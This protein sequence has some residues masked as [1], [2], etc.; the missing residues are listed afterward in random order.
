MSISALLHMCI[1]APLAAGVVALLVPKRLALLTKVLGVAVSAVMCIGAAGLFVA[2]RRAGG[3][4]LAAWPEWAGAWAGRPLL[5]LDGLSAL[6]LGASGVFVL[7]ISL[8]SAGFLSDEKVSPRSYWANFLWVAGAAAATLVSRDLLALTF[9]WAFMGIP[10]FLL[11]NL[12]SGEADAAAKKMLIVQG[13]TDGLLIL[14][15][16][17]IY[18]LT[19]S[20]DILQGSIPTSAAATAACLCVA[21]AALSKAGA[22]PLHSWVPDAAAS[23]PVPVAALLPASLDKLLGIYLFARISLGLFTIT[24]GLRSLFI[25]IGAVTVVAAVMMAMVQHNLRRL[26]GFHAV[27]QVGYMVLGIATGTAV[28]V[29]GGLFHMLN[30]AIYKA[31]LFLSGGAA[32]RRAGT[33]ELDRMGGLA[34][35]MPGTFV[36]TLISALAI[37]GVPPLNGF[38]SK[39]MVYRGLIEMGPGAG[40]WVVAL[41]AA[42]FGSALTLASF[43]KVLHSVFLGQPQVEGSESGPAPNFLMGIGMAVLAAGCVVFG[44]FAFRVPLALLILPALGAS[45]PAS[46]TVLGLTTWQPVLAALLLGAA[47]LAGL[48]IYLLARVPVR[49]DEA[50]IGGEVGRSA[51]RFRFSGTE[52]YRTVT[53]LPGLRTLY[54]HAEGGWYDV[55]E[56]GRRF[57]FYVAGVLQAFHSGLLL[58]YVAWCVAGVV[59]LLW[60]LSGVK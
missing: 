38:V 10:F 14:G 17:L 46:E 35:L 1:T 32:E 48:G 23:A 55:Y 8:Y 21:A 43:V 36:V 29:A 22:V 24:P 12:G 25:I 6:M 51:Q 39:W 58:T 19:G 49:E 34:R 7:L 4:D 54:R 31:C 45:A 57:V 18:R 42:M 33:G 30:N 47:L 59:V 27:S 15:I 26:L 3:L 11:V 37:S 16:G 9:F 20:F 28:G 53:E 44:I 52:F 2:E 60:V 5:A 50:Y 41:V 40:L 13:G 56:L